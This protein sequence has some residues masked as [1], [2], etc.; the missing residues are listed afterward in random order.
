MDNSIVH[1]LKSPSITYLKWKWIRTLISVEGGER[2][3]FLKS[4]KDL[5]FHLVLSPYGYK[6]KNEK[7]KK[8]LN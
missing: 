2:G 1:F 3:L 8:L 5:L 4:G 7:E 6:L